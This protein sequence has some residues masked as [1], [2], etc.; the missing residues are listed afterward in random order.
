MKKEEKDFVSQDLD[1][2]AGPSTQR[3]PTKTAISNLNKAIQRV[4]ELALS[5]EASA[6]KASR[7]PGFEHLNPDL[8]TAGFLFQYYT[9]SRLLDAIPPKVRNTA[10]RK[11]IIRIFPVVNDDVEKYARVKADLIRYLLLMQSNF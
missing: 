5:S 9:K 4:S 8:L 10:M 3:T 2:A 1:S 11:V 7:L 6:K